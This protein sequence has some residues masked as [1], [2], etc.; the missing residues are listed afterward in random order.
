MSF[1]HLKDRSVI[2]ITGKDTH[3]LL[4]GLITN[5]MNLLEED[6]ALYSALLTPQG[7]YL[8][9]FFLV[10]RGDTIYCDIYQP[11][12]ESFLKKL[13]MYRL[14]A[15]VQFEIL[16][17]MHVLTSFTNDTL[18]DA[19]AFKDPR[20]EQMGHRFIAAS[21]PENLRD[22]AEYH[23]HRIQH[24]IAEGAYDAVQDKT[25]L[26]EMG[27]DAI[28]AIDFHK[29]CYVG[30][31]VT[32]RSKYRANIRKKIYI[33]EA[34]AIFSD[35]DI[36]IV[37]GDVVLGERRSYHNHQALALLHSEKLQN[38]LDAKEKILCGKQEI[39]VKNV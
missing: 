24:G 36:E 2:K 16:E 4:Q 31:E 38:A 15:D 9:D 17:H 19:T 6:G 14:R 3:H 37:A 34:D 21:L 29:G 25:L 7:K 22:D 39:S 23:S 18:E 12:A 11:D 32:A 20:H 5:N 13:K 27:Y 10:Q 35:G 33:I 1:I 30:Q 26:L 8:Y 28:N